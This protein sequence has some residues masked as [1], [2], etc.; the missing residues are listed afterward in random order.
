VQEGKAGKEGFFL[1]KEAKPFAG[2][3]APRN[4]CRRR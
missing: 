3:A 2:A 4:P 1:K